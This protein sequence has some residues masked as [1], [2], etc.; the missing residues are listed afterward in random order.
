LKNNSYVNFNF[1]EP[2]P[3]NKY[4]AVLRTSRITYNAVTDQR[5]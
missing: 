3:I 1:D 2:E 4:S 5:K